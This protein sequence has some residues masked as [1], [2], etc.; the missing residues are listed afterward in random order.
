MKFKLWF[1]QQLQLKTPST[2]GLTL[3]ESIAAMVITTL[4]LTAIAPPLLFSAATRVQSRKAEQ[5]AAIARQEVTQVRA[6][7]SRKQGIPK[8]KELGNVPPAASVASLYN[9][10]APTTLVTAR[11]GLDNINKAVKIDA[12]GDGEND[13]FIQ[14]IRD[15]GV[16]FSNGV[17]KDQLAV[18]QMGVRVYDIAAADNLGNLNVEP[19]SLQI[20]KGL[21]ERTTHPLAVTY[22]EVS[23]S[24]LKLSLKE[25]REYVCQVK[26]TLSACL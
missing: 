16:R 8:A 9:A 21:G 14:L 2:Q 13:F 20:T 7:L 1:L 12:D 15:Q 5:A 6:A 26:P 24:D 23:R 22:T 17:A 19:A 4:I 25:Y 18:F 11:S 3:I 10:S